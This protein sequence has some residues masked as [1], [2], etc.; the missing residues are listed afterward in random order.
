MIT[1]IYKL[2]FGNG[3]TYIGKSIDIERRWKEHSEKMLCGTA[4]KNIQNVFNKYGLPNIT[5]LTECHSDHIDLMETYYIN[6][7]RP[8]LNGAKSVYVTGA[9]LQTFCDH[10][11]MLKYSTGTHLRTIIKYSEKD[12]S[13]QEE[14][15]ELKKFLDKERMESSMYDELV[16]AKEEAEKLREEVEEISYTVAKMET[17][18]WWQ[19]LFK[20]W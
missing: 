3:S 11:Y 14:L 19:R 12:L 7:F 16:A 9:D 17:A 5:V 4:A 8:D 15:D 10:M 2:T 18:S 1:G 13:K 6:Q 20:T